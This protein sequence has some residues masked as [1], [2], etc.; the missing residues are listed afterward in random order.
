MGAYTAVV[1]QTTTGR[2]LYDVD[3]VADPGWAT[4]L[5]GW[6]DS[7]QVVTPLQNRADATKVREWAERWFCS[8]AVLWDDVVC[9]AGPITQNPEFG[10]TEDLP[11]ITVSGKGFWENL[12]QRTLHARTWNPATAPISDVTA[13]LAV[14]D[15]LPNIAIN[16][17]YHATSMVSR[18]GSALPV[19]Y[20]ALVASDSN[21]RTYHGWEAASAGQRLQELTQVENGPDVYFRPYLT[22]VAGVRYVRHQMLVG[23]PYLVQ[24]GLPLKFDLGSSMV[25][26]GVA[27]DSSPM[28]TTSFVKGT[29]NEAGQLF[30]YATS[31]GLTSKGWPLLDQ[32][33]SSHA[34]ASEQSTLNS[35]ARAN[36]TQYGRKLEQW[37]PRVRL[38][39]EPRFGSYVP[40]HFGSYVVNDHPWIPDGTYTARILGVSSSGGAGDGVP[41]AE[42]QIEAIPATS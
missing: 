32:V 20:A 8:V 36:V 10:F 40:G 19:D 26:L 42:H 25:D 31:T 15:S 4:A 29:G 3:L 2:V 12:N 16:I 9:Q 22:N 35:W 30:G 5:N 37:K 1:Y 23:T 34:S 11:T 13:D 6:D 21:T 38:D 7:W 14:T 24:S 17:V 33:D 41:I 28:V 27:G 18:D 39:S